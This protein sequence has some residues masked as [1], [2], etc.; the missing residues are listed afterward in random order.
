MIGSAPA[1]LPAHRELF[2]WPAA[3]RI[4]HFLRRNPVL[5]LVIMAPMVEYLSGSTRVNYLV[6]DPAVFLILLAQNL[7]FYGAGVLL[8]REARIRWK[9][10][11]AS[12]FLLGAAYGILEEGVMLKTMFEPSLPGALSWYGRWLGVN[13]AFVSGVVLVHILFSICLPILLLDLALPETRGVSLLSRKGILAVGVIWAID[14]AVTTL[15]VGRYW[16]GY[17]IYFGAV[18][19]ILV[20]VAVALTLPRW[21]RPIETSPAP[22]PAAGLAIGIA[23]LLSQLLWDDVTVGIGRY[24][25]FAVAG[26]IV[27]GLVFLVLARRI[28]EDENRRRVQVAFATGSSVALM[29]GGIVE[30]FPVELNLAY[31][32][33]LLVFLYWLWRMYP[34]LPLGSTRSA[35]VPPAG[36]SV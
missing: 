23:I 14:F 27:M 8:I 32:A 26:L 2:P 34:P 36:L 28:L 29:F 21:M 12:V 4:K 3:R 7:G 25:T 30:N 16:P 17:V 22:S 19:V 24:A 33:V 31:D 9:L 18:L 11:W 10:R 35:V 15:V 5:C 6:L 13:W 1:N 20:L